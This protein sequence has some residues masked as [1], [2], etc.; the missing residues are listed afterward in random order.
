MA[1]RLT[2]CG[3][4]TP[5]RPDVYCLIDKLRRDF[6]AELQVHEVDCMAACDDSPA[7]MIEYDYYPRVTANLLR[8]LVEA[9]I[10]T[11]QVKA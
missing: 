11:H 5:S 6:S 8:Q 10:A 7:V 3:L 9:R 2:L 1:V 4:C